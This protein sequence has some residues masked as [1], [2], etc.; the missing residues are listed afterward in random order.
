M[1]RPFQALIQDVLNRWGG[2]LQS[3]TDSEYE[4]NFE[5]ADAAVNAALALHQGLHGVDWHGPAPGLRVGIHVGQIVR[6]GGADEAR[7][8][9]V[10][11]AM[12]VCRRLTGMAAAGQT[13]LT[14]VAFDMRGNTSGRP[15][16]RAGTAS[17]S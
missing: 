2:R 12:D 8:L 9:Q 11:R 5:T 10:G 16:P 7:E 15:R 13:L 6:F 4:V 1:V 14:R 17:S 3:E